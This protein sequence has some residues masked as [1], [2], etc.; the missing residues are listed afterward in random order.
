MTRFA[1]I[2]LL[3]AAISLAGCGDP[4]EIEQLRGNNQEMTARLAKFDVALKQAENNAAILK[5]ANQQ[6]LDDVASNQ[7]RIRKLE[8]DLN[9]ALENLRKARQADGTLPKPPATQ[10][11]ADDPKSM[12]LA[13]TLAG[14]VGFA[15]GSA[16]LKDAAKTELD[17][18]VATLA[19]KHPSGLLAVCGHTDSDPILKSKW[20]NNQALS[21]ARAGA[22][23]KVL[24]DK[25]VSIRRIRVYGYGALWPAGPEHTPA[26]KA[27]NRR[28]EI[29]AA[30]Q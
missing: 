1:S 30:V 6:L 20:K 22:V 11:A 25:G 4:K 17:K 18:A 23:A 19:E 12:T 13:F 14:D 15:P 9:K 27:A 8:A 26:Q 28:V 7:D 21:E 29:R 5:T 3:A 10:P 16:E 24:I 2:A